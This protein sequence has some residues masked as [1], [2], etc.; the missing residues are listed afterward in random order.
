MQLMNVDAIQAKPLQAALECCYEMLRACVVRPLAGAG[1]FP[2]AFGC[3]DQ[4]S[5]IRIEC[6]CDQLFGCTGSVGVRR[7]DQIHAK[8]NRMPESRKSSGFVGG[9]S[10]HTWPSD[11][12]RAI[13]HSVDRKITTDGERAGGCG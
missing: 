6:F 7:I 8:F 9:R 3:D 1:A 10:P 2:S 4:S 11:A 12:H 5:G 13:A